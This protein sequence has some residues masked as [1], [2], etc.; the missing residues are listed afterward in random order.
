MNLSE[1]RFLVK[2]L[3]RLQTQLTLSHLL[4]TIISVVIFV[5]GLAVGYWIYLHSDFSAAWAGDTADFYAD[6]IA[7]LLEEECEDCVDEYLSAEFFPVSDMPEHD[8]W[9]IVIDSEG[10]ILGSNYPDLFPTG[11]TAWNHYPFGTTSADF[12]TQIVYHQ[13]EDRHFAVAPIPTGGWVY[14]HSG[15]METIIQLQ[16]TARIALWMSGALGI[17]ALLLSGVM[18]G[19]LGGFFGRKLTQLRAASSAFASGNLSERVPLTGN[20]EIGLLG[21]QFNLMADTIAQQMSDLRELAETNAQLAEEAEGLARLEERNRLARELHD[22]VKQQLFGLNLTLGS[23]STLLD[24]KPEIARE[25]LQQVVT[26]TQ[27]IQVELDQIIKQ[28]RPAS[29]QDQGLGSAVRQL[30][31]EWSQQTGIET[32][33][34]IQHERTLSLAIEQTIYRIAQEALQN[35]GKHAHATRVTITIQYEQEQLQ[36]Q[37]S[38]NGIGFDLN[39]VDKINSFGLQ[40][41]NQRATALGGVLKIDPTSK[42]TSITVILPTM[43]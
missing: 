7:S 41:M 38:D 42:G 24:K 36:M 40:N 1:P 12:T 17:I 18:G 11:E 35:V 5:V 29:L 8:E 32:V 10:T 31:A 33:V 13:L 43:T 22:A 21:R 19:W 23:I 25:R 3:M 37:F 20:D 34:T 15:A 27:Q 26:Q 2:K 30:A 39:T 28:M 14:Y 6:D 9:M 4:V 16:E